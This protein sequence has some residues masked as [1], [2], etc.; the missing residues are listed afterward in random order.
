ML[1]G[2]SHV[3]DTGCKKLC[4]LRIGGTRARREAREMTEKMYDD[5]EGVRL[6]KGSVIL[7]EIAHSFSNATQVEVMAVYLLEGV[8]DGG[9]SFLEGLTAPGARLDQASNAFAV[10]REW[11]DQ[12]PNES[13][14]GKLFNVLSSELMNPRIALKFKSRLIP[15]R[16][17]NTMGRELPVASEDACSSH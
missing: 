3:C 16:S 2:E 1:W 5:Q 15:A 8:K 13:Y 11:C 17:S 7:L 10:L 14:G 4:N 12:K 6:S 9:A